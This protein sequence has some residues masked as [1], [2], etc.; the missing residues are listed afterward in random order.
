MPP[1]SSAG[2]LLRGSKTGPEPETTFHK[3]S[4]DRT[5]QSV[6]PT[7]QLAPLAAGPPDRGRPPCRRA[8][9]PDA[10]RMLPN[11]PGPRQSL[12]TCYPRPPLQSVFPTRQLAPGCWRLRPRTTPMPPGSSAGCSLG[13]WN[14][15]PSRQSRFTSYP[16]T[17]LYTER[18][19][20]A[21]TGPRLLAPARPRTTLCR[22]AHPPDAFRMGSSRARARDNHFSQVDPM[23]ALSERLHRRVNWP[24]VAGALPD[25]L[26]RRLLAGCF[27]GYGNRTPN[28]RQSLFTCYP[29]TVLYRASSPTRQL[30]PGCWR[31]PTALIKYGQIKPI[32]I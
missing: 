31:P 7:R 23:T 22:R 14:Q 15:G 13:S 4:Y 16:M 3:L 11:R 2:C 25:D 26:M 28:P 5:L 6:F 17:A 20:D 10:F 21:S 9:P 30:A 29:M 24:P 1:G 32:I 12:F 19:T 27:R 18:L 8:H